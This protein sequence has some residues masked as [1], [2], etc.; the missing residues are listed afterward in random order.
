MN[1]WQKEWSWS[2]NDQRK[3]ELYLSAIGVVCIGI[4]PVL[5]ILIARERRTPKKIDCPFEIIISRKK[6]IW[7]VRTINDR[8]SHA[9][10]SETI[11]HAVARRPN[12]LELQT[13][14]SLGKNG[15]SPKYIL[16]V[17]RKEFK[18]YH[19]TAREIF[20]VLEKARQDALNGRTPIMALIDVLSNGEYQ[21]NSWMENDVVVGVFFAYK[22]SLEFIKRFN[23]VFLMD[24]TYQTN[25]PLLNIIGMTSMYYKLNIAENRR[26]FIY[27]SYLQCCVCISSKRGDCIL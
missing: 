13:I 27:I 9:V 24:C 2:R 3:T 19:T 23:T 7:A 10:G 22:S 5:R 16:S 17:L 8:H 15:D 1:T 4:R 25:M 18:N 20:N 21:K 12:E 6:G 14:I 26:Y 11:G